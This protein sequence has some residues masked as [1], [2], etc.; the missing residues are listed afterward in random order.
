MSVPTELPSHVQIEEKTS[1][2]LEVLKAREP[3]LSSW[4][5]LRHKL[6]SELYEMLG[7]VLDKNEYAVG[8]QVA[9]GLVVAHENTIKLLQEQADAKNDLREE[10]HKKDLQVEELKKKEQWQIDEYLKLQE[11][12]HDR[13]EK[14]TAANQLVEEFQEG[15]DYDQKV[16]DDFAREFFGDQEGKLWAPG[17][18]LKKLL[19]MIRDNGISPKK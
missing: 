5:E 11:M 12:A 1:R 3:G 14:L 10:L 2:F 15:A 16:R 17:L 7:A 4:R 6:G 9:P 8:Q 13:L 19:E 18:T